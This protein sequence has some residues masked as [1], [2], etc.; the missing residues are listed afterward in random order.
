MKRMIRLISIIVTLMVLLSGCSTMQTT[1]STA[2]VSA[3]L[4]NQPYQLRVRSGHF[5]MDRTIYETAAPEFST[6][7]T[8]SS[9]GPYRGI[10]EIIY[11]GLSD[12]SFLEATSDF[13]T[14]SVLGN[15][16]YIGT[17]YIELSG[18]DA[19]RE[20]GSTTAHT[21]M[22]EDNT[23]RINIKGLQ[24]ER[25]WTADYKHKSVYTSDNEQKVLKRAIK[26]IVEQL[27][28]DF[29]AIGESTR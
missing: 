7:L 18:S 19:T 17:G 13:T 12:S 3:L 29:P 23:M 16:W 15:A 26:K 28:K 4:H 27:R 6:Y 20:T 11:A 9:K 10:I 8:I 1:K 21:T 5:I 24:E 14:G 22:P 2:H 25:L